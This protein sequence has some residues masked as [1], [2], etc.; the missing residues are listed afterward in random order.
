VSELTARASVSPEVAEAFAA[1]AI[2]QFREIDLSGPGLPPGHIGWVVPKFRWVIRDDD[3]RLADALLKAVG[4]AAGA[5]FFVGSVT[6]TAVIGV[7][8]ALFTMCFTIRRK[9]AIISER[10]TQ[11]L[12]ALNASREPLS[13]AELADRLNSMKVDDNP[14]N[15]EE[16]EHLLES[17]QRVRLRD[18]TVVAIVARDGHGLWA[19]AG[20]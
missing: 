3:L 5:N 2:Q 8:S 4:A 13:A 14:W 15:V 1:H 12:V 18:G 10:E 19:C 7:A 17:L 11:L 16:T 9:G 20:V 6:A